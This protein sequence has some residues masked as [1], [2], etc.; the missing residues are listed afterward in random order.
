MFSLDNVS[1]RVWAADSLQTSPAVMDFIKCLFTN[2][3][4]GS[5][6]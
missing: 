5:Q 3:K 4:G 2:R 6:Y 1:F